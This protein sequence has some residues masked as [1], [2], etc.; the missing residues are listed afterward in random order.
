MKDMYISGGVNVYPA[1]IG[2]VIPKDPR[3]SEAAAIGIEDHKCGEVGC[4]AN[5]PREGKK[6]GAQ[7]IED[8]CKEWIAGYKV[9]IRPWP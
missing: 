7:Q 8:L 3:I 6:V 2:N 5:V 1:E 9:P 4:A